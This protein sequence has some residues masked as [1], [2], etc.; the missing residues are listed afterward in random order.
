MRRLLPLAAAL[1]LA[2][3]LV[4]AP[5]AWA[6][7]CVA[8]ATTESE[9]KQADVVFVGIVASV[10]Q[11]TNDVLARFTVKDVYKGTVPG[12]AGVHTARDV[13]ACG[14]SFVPGTRYAVFATVAAGAYQANLC[15]GTT[16][17][18]RALERA[19]FHPGSPAAPLAATT[20]AVSHPVQRTGPLVGA[21][22]LIAVVVGGVLLYRRT[23]AG[24]APPPPQ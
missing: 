16:E 9:F 23:R 24:E 13:A 1:A 4:H 2:G 15:G 3:T 11:G 19:G 20:P 14:V 22:L 5:M 18:V 17:D 8:N 6:C 21:A 12:N 10:S 7:S